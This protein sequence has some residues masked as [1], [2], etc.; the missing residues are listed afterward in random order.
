MSTSPVDFQKGWA[1]HSLSSVQTP[2][3]GLETLSRVEFSAIH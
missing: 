1:V 3:L 2:W